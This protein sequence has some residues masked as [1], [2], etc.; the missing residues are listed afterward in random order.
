M[1]ARPGCRTGRLRRVFGGYEQVQGLAAKEEA[2]L[3][4]LAVDLDGTLTLSDTLH[5]GCL[6]Y[7]KTGLQDVIDLAARLG[8][9]KAAFK[10]AVADRTDFDPALLPYN[11]ELLNYL[12]AQKRAGRTIALV[13]AAD[14]SIAD[15]VAAHLGLF[16]QARGSQHGVNLSG[17]RK[18][19]VIR[20]ML[21]ERFVYAGDGPVDAPIFAAADAVI[22][23]GNVDRLKLLLPAGKSIEQAFAVKRAGARTWAKALR[24]QHWA[25]NV[26]VFV[27]PVLGFSYATP[28]LAMNAVLLFFAMSILASATYIVNDL[29]DLPSDRQHPRKRHRPFAAGAIAP[30]DGAFA[31]IALFALSGLISLALPIDAAAALAAY[32]GVTLS[33]SLILKRQPIIDVFVL[34][35]LFTLRVLAGSLLAPQPVS[36]WL[37]T[38]SM[39]IFLGL[40]M[41]KR[42]AE[43][44]RVVQAGGTGVVS[45]GYTVR[46][47]PLL[48]AAGIASS[49]SAIVIFMVYLINEQYPRDIYTHPGM[50]WALMPLVLIWILRVWHLTVH[51]RMS[52]DPVVFALKDRF[53]LLL[54]LLALLVLFA[55]T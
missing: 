43:L 3:P 29:L 7:V 22:L 45:R 8:E 2:S 49:F 48:L 16:D 38:F 54:G 13:T 23:V 25:K 52:E 20:Q 35:G 40:A 34:A 1:F 28:V 5:E 4:P 24:L 31:A 26:L 19:A 39:L 47:L 27:A 30:R 37:L 36:P 51:G 44:N 55:A 9:G 50:L 12:K 10:R 33:Y 32:A 11:S 53:S 46:D 6:A 41:V 15:A 21:G 18:L 17:A 14:Q 42:Y